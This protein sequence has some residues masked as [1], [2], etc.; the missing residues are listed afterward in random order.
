MIARLSLRNAMAALVALAV[1]AMAGPAA[2]QAQGPQ[3][4]PQ[5]M[6][7][8]K[9]ILELKGAT[10]MFAPLV[11]GVVEKVRI[12]VLNDN[13]MWQRDIDEAAAVAHKNFDSRS[14]EL[15]DATARIYASHF[16]EAEL[17][18][19]LA[20]YQS[21]LGQKSI[22]EEPKAVDEA[23]TN[24]GKWGDALAVEVMQTMR[25]E[26]KKRGHDL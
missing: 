12:T 3:P 8:A 22:V 16:T 10:A 4:S 2:P 19:L 11:R 18:Q 7:V 13:F 20:F 15:V 9:Q 6:L 25:V 1:I 17:K 5:A 14:V 21:P 24:A 23:M 26:L